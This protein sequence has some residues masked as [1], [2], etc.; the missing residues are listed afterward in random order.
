MG[1]EGSRR[2]Q[3][4][5]SLLS[6]AF[7]SRSERQLHHW[8]ETSLGPERSRTM[9]ASAQRNFVGRARIIA[10]HAHNAPM[11][12]DTG[13]MEMRTENFDSAIGCFEQ[14]RTDYAKREDIMRCV[15]EECDALIKSGKRKR[16]L[17][18][19]RSVLSIVPDSPASQLLRKLE[20]EL[21]PKP[22]PAATARRG[23]S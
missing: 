3:F 19:A 9:A 12:E 7:H 11:L 5:L 18:L 20:T 22:T 21:T 10:S 17:D 14:A 6:K 16:A 15:L 2:T 23:G 4:I 1:G 8:M 13:L